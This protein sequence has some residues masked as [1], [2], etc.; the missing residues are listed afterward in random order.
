M[1]MEGLGFVGLSR[2]LNQDASYVFFNLLYM[3]AMSLC[4]VFENK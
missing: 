3:I 2:S 4:M 1:E